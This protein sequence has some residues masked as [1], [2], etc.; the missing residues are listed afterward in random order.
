MLRSKP[1]V[2]LG[3]IV[4]FILIVTQIGFHL[5]S[6]TGPSKTWTYPSGFDPHGGYLDR[7]TFVVYSHEDAWTAIEAL[8][9]NIIY[10]YDDSVPR[11]RLADCEVIFPIGVEVQTEPGDTYLA[12]SIDC[13]QFPTN[14]TGYRRAIAYALDKSAVIQASTGGLAFLQDCVLPINL[15]NWTYERQLLETYYAQNIDKANTILQAAGFKD[16]NGDG[17]RDYDVDNDSFWN[18]IIDLDSMAIEL[19]ITYILQQGPVY[20]NAVELAVQGLAKCGIR[21]VIDPFDIY[22]MGI[23]FEWIVCCF[24]FTNMVSA[25][26]LYDLF[27]SSTVN[28]QWYFGGWTNDTYDNYAENLL[29]SQTVEEANHWAWKCQEILWHEQPMIVCY[30]DVY[31]HTYRTDRWEGY[32]NMACRNRMGDNPWTLRK[33][34][35][36]ESEGGTWGCYPTEYILALTEGLDTTNIIMSDSKYS[37]RVFSQ[38][39]NKLWQYDPFNWE[40][41]PDLAYHWEIEST[42]SSGDIQE[43]EKFTFYLYENA[44]WH[45]GT[46]LTA[47]DVDRSVTLAQL[48]PYNSENYANIYMT[49][50]LNNSTVEIYTN[51]TGYFEW[52]HSTDFTI[53]PWHIWSQI[54]NITEWEPTSPLELTGSGPF[55]WGGRVPGQYIRLNLF[56][57]YHLGDEQPPRIHCYNPIPLTLYGLIALGIIVIIVQVAILGYLFHRRSV[58][59]SIKN[60]AYYNSSSWRVD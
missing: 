4:V 16:L 47:T 8:A 5:P 25:D 46:P 15:S 6:Q 2:W 3:V 33:L 55:Q 1:L 58:R 12:F 35:L 26:L 24:T 51:K 31:I 40:P 10:A 7:V 59:K 57:G 36:K 21:S 41:I 29:S 17:W 48:D 23:P 22:T 27:H 60:S 14:I 53:L 9:G 42:N 30:N 49:N 54:E 32:V 19:P 44:T 34:H 50:I 39:Y 52:T 18:P 28:N 38:I 13:G 56:T 20:G 45:D 11:D 43:G 37:N